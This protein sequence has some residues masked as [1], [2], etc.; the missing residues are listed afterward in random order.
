MAGYGL[1]NVSLVSVGATIRAE[2]PSR[3]ANCSPLGGRQRTSF[4]VS[5]GSYSVW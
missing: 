5:A 2:G 3:D 4:I 1:E